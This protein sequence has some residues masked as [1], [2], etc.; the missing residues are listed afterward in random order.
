LETFSA[1]LFQQLGYRAEMRGGSGD[2]GVDVQLTNSFGGLEVVQCKQ[3]RS[4]VGEPE[5]RAFYGTL[6][7]SQA[8]KG[9]FVAPGGF[10]RQARR[11]AS[12]KP[13]VLADAAVLAHLIN[14][15]GRA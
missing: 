8:V 13:I 11:W 2:H 9:Y 15:A 14:Q 10:T 5:M 6:V 12:G 3:Y 1:R 7:H 4:P